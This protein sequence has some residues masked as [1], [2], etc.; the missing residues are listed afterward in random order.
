M[1]IAC[2]YHSLVSDWNHGN[3]HFLRGVVSELLARRHEVRVWEPRGGW[4]RENLV[5]DA[6]E[7]RPLAGDDH[8]P[9][10]PI[11]DPLERGQVLR[12]VPDAT[13]AEDVRLLRVRAKP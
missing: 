12:L 11:G 7:T 2:F 5:A 9:R 6:A 1:R 10:K 4:S 8:R 13:G 3:A